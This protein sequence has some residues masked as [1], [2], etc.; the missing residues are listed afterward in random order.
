MQKNDTKITISELKELVKNFVSARQWENFHTLKNLSMALSVESS[1]LME[2]LLWT[3]SGHKH[4]LS[5]DERLKEKR[6]EIE[7][8]IADIFCYLLSFC[9][10]AHIDLSKA[11]IHK[12]KLNAEKYPVAECLTKAATDIKDIYKKKQ[13]TKKI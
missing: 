10:T 2:L 9:N 5:S 8:E 13:T 7:N 4:S 12:M 1:E 6:Q 3:D 11:V